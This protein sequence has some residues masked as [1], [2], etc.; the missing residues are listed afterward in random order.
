MQ[1]TIFQRPS[2]VITYSKE[3]HA[4]NCFDKEEMKLNRQ[5]MDQNSNS[6]TTFCVFRIV[7]YVKQNRNDKSNVEH[8][9]V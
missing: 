5:Y 6:E 9:Q 8:S 2:Y 3:L 1:W 7:T 4:P